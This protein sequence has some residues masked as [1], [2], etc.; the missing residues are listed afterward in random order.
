MYRP[1]ML[2]DID[3][4]R[5]QIFRVFPKDGEKQRRIIDMRRVVGCSNSEREKLVRNLA[6]QYLFPESVDSLTNPVMCLFTLRDLIAK[7]LSH[8]KKLSDLVAMCVVFVYLNEPTRGQ[9]IAFLQD[10]QLKDFTFTSDEKAVMIEAF[11]TSCV[12]Q[13]RRQTTSLI[14]VIRLCEKDDEYCRRTLK[15]I[16]EQQLETARGA[17]RQF[18]NELSKTLGFGSVPNDWTV[19]SPDRQLNTPNERRMQNTITEKRVSRLFNVCQGD[20]VFWFVIIV[21]IGLM[22]AMLLLN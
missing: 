21:I 22:M 15:F 2:G 7:S 12:L 10:T 4:R 5:G 14:N 13:D 6:N 1:F 19:A 11:M 16:M 18:L 9:A 17:E 20:K 3:A 8:W